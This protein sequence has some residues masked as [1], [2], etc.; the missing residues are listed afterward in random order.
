MNSLDT[1]T[2]YMDKNNF[3]LLPT[4]RHGWFKY[5]ISVYLCFP[6]V[7]TFVI[8]SFSEK[9]FPY[10]IAF[11]NE[12]TQQNL[13]STQNIIVIVKVLEDCS[14]VKARR[15]IEHNKFETEFDE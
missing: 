10:M 2:N 8:S 12:H 15:S 4:I 1:K 13:S 11:H 3:N 9:N 14:R 7:I 5:V 6:V